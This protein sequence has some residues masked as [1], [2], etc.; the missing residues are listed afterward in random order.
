MRSD[1]ENVNAIVREMVTANKRDEKTAEVVELRIQL[2]TIQRLVKR[3]G[4]NSHLK[5]YLK[6]C[7]AT[8]GLVK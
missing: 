3:Y 1:P 7:R 5:A 6:A 8:K 2:R 4:G